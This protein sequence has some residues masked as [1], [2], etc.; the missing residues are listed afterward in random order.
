MKIYTISKKIWMALFAFVLMI[1]GS[2]NA[3]AETVDYLYDFDNPSEFAN[4]SD[5]PKG[6]VADGTYPFKR[7]TRSYFTGSGAAYS[8][9]YCVGVAGS[10]ASVRDEHIYTEMLHL[11][12][13]VEYTLS[14]MMLAPGGNAPTVFYSWATATVGKGQ[15]PAEQTVTLGST[16]EGTS[17][18]TWTRF[19]FK[20]T[21]TET[22]DYSFALAANAARYN[23]GAILFDD[24][25]ITGSESGEVDPDPG[26]D[27]DPDVDPVDPQPAS[28]I[29]YNFDNDLTYAN[30]SDLPSGWTTDGPYA[31]KRGKM[32]D[33]DCSGSA[34]SGEY[35]VGTPVCANSSNKEHLY[36]SHY[37]FT[38]GKEY[39]LNF[40]IFAPSFYTY[41]V[42]VNVTLGTEAGAQVIGTV[43]EAEYA[44]WKEFSF[45][46]VP[47]KTGD[48]PVV[49]AP[50][51]AP[52]GAILFDDISF[53]G[54]TKSDIPDP[55]PDP[56]E[57]SM[58]YLSHETKDFGT[59]YLGQ[60]VI[61]T[62]YVT[63]KGIT[64]DIEISE[65]TTGAV[66][67][68]TN[69]IS[70][71]DAMSEKGYA[72]V[73]A[74][75][76]EDLETTED[77]LVFTCGD[78]T[79]TYTMK[80]TPKEEEEGPVY[81]D[82]TVI[83]IPYMETFDD[84]EHYDGKSY[85]PIGWTCTGVTPFVTASLESIV[86]VSGTYYM[87]TPESDE[88]RDERVYTPFFEMKAGVPY[89]AS[90]YLYMPGRQYNGAWRLN[91][92]DFSI[93]TEQ[94]A[95]MQTEVLRQFSVTSIADWTKVTCEYTPTKDGEYCYSFHFTSEVNYTG[96]IAVENF[97]ITAPGSIYKPMPDFAIS[98]WFNL[99]TSCAV[100]F[101][102]QPVK[103][104][105]LTEYADSYEWKVK[106]AQPETST[107]INPSFI[108]PESG[109]YTI[110]MTATN[111]VG[112][113][114]TYKTLDIEDFSEGAEQAALMT[115]NPEE[116]EYLSKYNNIPTFS[117]DATYDF[118]S[119]PNHYYKQLAERFELPSDQEITITNLS[120]W[121]T[122]FGRMMQYNAADRNTPFSIVFYGEKN[123][124]VDTSNV[125]G[126]KVSTLVDEFGEVGIGLE[127]SCTWGFKIPDAVTV[128]GPF[129][130][131]FEFDEKY[132]IDSPDPNIT[133]SY[134]AFGLIK[135]K[136]NLTSLYCKPTAGPEGFTP[137]GEWC[138]L[139]KLDANMRGYG[140][141]VVIWCSVAAN[142]GVGINFAL[143]NGGDLL[144]AIRNDYNILTVSGTSENENIRIY[145]MQGKLVQRAN[146]RNIG[147]DIS[148]S[149]L[150]AGV[151]TVKTS[152]GSQKF[153]K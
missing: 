36:T 54:L 119:G 120:I 140:I 94:A 62:L 78:L 91:S 83:E 89:T 135:H 125:F 132:P 116:D 79:V 4:E 27:P 59:A 121:L 10:S 24:I 131:A 102:N 7:G 48:I 127:N 76:P 12:A 34:H 5:L 123:N 77:Q 124:T 128:K 148:I 28:T 90:F 144:F 32:A 37:H 81:P 13:G 115:Y 118:I 39:T 110:E 6:W 103:M 60:T 129:Y 84:A 16:P 69:S 52:R 23:C 20:F 136:S 99:Y 49:F 85:L 31:F 8:G 61:D 42:G 107:D 113:R 14:F 153:I 25:E 137:D 41:K 101:K 114:T 86:P 147:T 33:F 93:G 66:I 43:P 111:A 146:G 67:V 145:D 112:S 152:K 109:V 80:W 55:S 142:D 65:P 1:V 149:Q 87:I 18:T 138:S 141:N 151:Y 92:L 45:T 38:A 150:P 70:A 51:K 88:P 122:A 106:G 98:S 22:A 47:E 130:V 19:E 143:G 15:T 35:V 57:V 97:T 117:T 63:A 44:Q 96:F 75:T 50:T 68:S 133:R 72:V 82:H 139:D 104:V 3:M 17:Y 53:S 26:V 64:D 11:Q 73:V 100:A 2:I 30:E 56:Q 21:P 126:K 46:F 29:T 74:L 71:A 105:N 134:S 95:N 40:W 58:I 9:S 108:F